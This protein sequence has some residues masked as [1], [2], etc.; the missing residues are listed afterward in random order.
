L[1]AGKTVTTADRSPEPVADQ[2]DLTTR[3]RRL[4]DALILAAQ[5]DFDNAQKAVDVGMQDELGVVEALAKALI[6][7]YQTAIRQ[8]EVSLEEFTVSRR[9]LL[10]Q[11]DTVKQ[12]RAEI[13]TLSAPILDVAEDVVAIPLAGTIGVTRLEEM[14]ER[15][16]HRIATAGISTVIIDLT[17]IESVDTESVEQL[18]RVADAVRLMG[19][20]CLWTGIPPNVAKTLVSLGTSLQGIIPMASLK[21]GLRY[22]TR[23][24][25]RPA[26]KGAAKR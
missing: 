21:E 9:E 18:L 25:V 15:L 10:A 3:F 17:G 19:A 6:F 2:S 1:V 20:T 26:A 13:R 16:L 12:Q 24:S 8:N 4:R 22:C 7:D 14:S 11:L 5:G 23:R